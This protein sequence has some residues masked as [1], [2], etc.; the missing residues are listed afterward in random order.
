MN[1]SWASVPTKLSAVM[2]MDSEII[3]QNNNVKRNYLVG[4]PYVLHFFVLSSLVSQTLTWLFHKITK[5]L[6]YSGYINKKVAEDK[7][8]PWQ[9]VIES[10]K[11]EW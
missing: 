3:I 7:L 9:K 4:R 2:I 6:N 5:L 8:E 1:N 11:K 10:G